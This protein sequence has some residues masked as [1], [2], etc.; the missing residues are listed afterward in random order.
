MGQNVI[1]IWR[2]FVQS[3]HHMNR[4]M[5]VAQADSLPKMNF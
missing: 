2:T 4:L 1:W 5:A 3:L